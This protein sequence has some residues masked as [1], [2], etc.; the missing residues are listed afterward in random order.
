MDIADKIDAAIAKQAEAVADR[1]ASDK[2]EILTSALTLKSEMERRAGKVMGG[3]DFLEIVERITHLYENANDIA[4]K[5]V[6][7]VNAS[8]KLLD[9]RELKRADVKVENGF[10]RRL[11]ASFFEAQLRELDLAMKAKER[12]T[13][14]ALARQM[15]EIGVPAEF[16]PQ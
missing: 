11:V 12:Q 1:V 3:N 15:S 8:N 13:S 9:E 10:R 14:K 4:R 2:D 16:L 7:D 5:G 6:I